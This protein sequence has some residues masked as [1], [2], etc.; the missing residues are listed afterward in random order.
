MEHVI[1]VLELINYMIPIIMF[2][3]CNIRSFTKEQIAVAVIT[4]II[5]LYIGLLIFVYKNDKKNHSYGNKRDS[6]D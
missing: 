4:L 1:S 5:I 3:T 6:E 2:T